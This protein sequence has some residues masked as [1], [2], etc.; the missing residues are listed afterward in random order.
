[1]RKKRREKLGG[2]A[3]IGRLMGGR[4]G[5]ADEMMSKQICSGLTGDGEEK[6][7]WEGKRGSAETTKEKT[8]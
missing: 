4:T 3:L 5:M 8:H 6:K 2:R 7:H 1:V